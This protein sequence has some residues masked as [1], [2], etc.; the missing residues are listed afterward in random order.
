ME[1][2]AKQ[3]RLQLVALYLKEKRRVASKRE[4]VLTHPFFFLTENHL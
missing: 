1:E 3:A 4:G 2:Q